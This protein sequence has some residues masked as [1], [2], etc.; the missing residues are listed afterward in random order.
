M[1]S[2]WLVL[3]KF[4][5]WIFTELAEAISV[6]GEHESQRAEKILEVWKGETWCLALKN[7]ARELPTTQFNFHPNKK[8]WNK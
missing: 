2:S 4:F 6:H 5:L 8:Y 3:M 7:Y 1:L